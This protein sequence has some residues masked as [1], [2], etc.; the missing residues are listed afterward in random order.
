MLTH[1]D[2]YMQMSENEEELEEAYGRELKTILGRSQNESLPRDLLFEVNG[3]FHAYIHTYIF[4]IYIYIYM[5]VCVC[6]CMH[7][8]AHTKNTCIG[9][10]GE[11]N[12]E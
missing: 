6:V 1:I 10:G 9:N 11:V 12:A 8:Y 3:R 4:H 2:A 5:Y 7:T